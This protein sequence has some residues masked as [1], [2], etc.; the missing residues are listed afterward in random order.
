MAAT[1]WPACPRNEHGRGKAAFVPFVLEGE[2]GRSRPARAKAGLCSSTR[3]AMHR[4]FATARPSRRAL[5]FNAAEA[6]L[7]A[8]PLRTSTGDQ[9]A[10][11][12]ENLRRIAKLELARNCA[13]IPPLRGIIATAPG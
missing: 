11:L 9:S 7:P 2:T 3:R 6:A 5:I 13:S 1:V 12:K 10:I 8:R 4:S